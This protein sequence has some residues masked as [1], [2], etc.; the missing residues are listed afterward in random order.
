MIIRNPYGFVVKHFKLINLILIIPMIYLAFK[1]GDI[2]SFFN[3]YIAN[4]YS[5]PETSF[6]DM[7]VNGTMYLIIIAL[8]FANIFLYVIFTSKKRM[9]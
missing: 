9:D 4:G 8:L 6:A 5:T 2:T 1:L 3:S 7:Y